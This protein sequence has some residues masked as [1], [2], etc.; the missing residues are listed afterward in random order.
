VF[1]VKRN[2]DGCEYALK[3]VKL[4][5]LSDKEKANA[6]NEVRILASIEHPNIICYK[7]SF[8]DENNLCIIMELCDG[9][10]VLQ[11]IEMLTRKN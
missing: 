8:F 1:K 5:S 11:K 10:D 2:S 4:G 3:K 9:G 7:E 6:L